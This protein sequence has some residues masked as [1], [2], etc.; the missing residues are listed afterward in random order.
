MSEV[1]DLQEPHEGQVQSGEYERVTFTASS[2][3]AEDDVY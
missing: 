1:G 2:I 3:L